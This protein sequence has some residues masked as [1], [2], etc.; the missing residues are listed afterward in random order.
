MRTAA[1]KKNL[2]KPYTDTEEDCTRTL[3]RAAAP[4]GS[5]SSGWGG[6][7]G[8]GGWGLRVCDTDEREEFPSIVTVSERPWIGCSKVCSKVCSKPLIG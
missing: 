7:V 6:L 4:G 3:T 8:W 5:N 2:T 1:G